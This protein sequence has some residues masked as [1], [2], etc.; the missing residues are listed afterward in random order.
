MLKLLWL[1]FVTDTVSFA[2]DWGL[3]LTPWGTCRVGQIVWRFNPQ[4]PREFKH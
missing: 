2:W 1:C 4:P 3:D